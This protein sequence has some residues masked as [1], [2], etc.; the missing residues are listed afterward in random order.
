LK[1]SGGVEGMGKSMAENQ[2]KMFKTAIDAASLVFAHSVVD[3][4]LL[5]FLRVT[6]AHNHLDWSAFVDD[7]QIAVSAVQGKTYDDIVKDKVREYVES[8]DRQSLLM[9][10]DRMFQVCRPPAGFEPMNDYKFDRGRLEKLDK[11]RHD[12]VH[13]PGPVTPLENSDD[14]IWYLHKTTFYFFAM[15]NERYDTRIDPKLMFT[16]PG[17]GA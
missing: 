15:V 6:V 5:D 16:Q 9:K 8:L 4:S 13:G 3:S 1:A 14:E 2:L 7:K 11:L 12:I 10:I 17:N